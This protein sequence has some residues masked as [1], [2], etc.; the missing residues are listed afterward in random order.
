MERR[1][2]HEEAA[3]DR[4]DEGAR[5]GTGGVTHLSFDG[6]SAGT[7]KFEGALANASDTKL[8]LRVSRSAPSGAYD[9]RYDDVVFD[10]E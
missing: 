2:P 3:G 7:T 8:Y 9:V 10:Y 5:C 1:V 6:A 4:R